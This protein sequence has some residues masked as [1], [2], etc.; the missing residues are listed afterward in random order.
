MRGAV[1]T[2]SGPVSALPGAP[3]AVVAVIM[4][5]LVLIPLPRSGAAGA[6]VPSP[7]NY[8][9]SVGDSYASGYQPVASATAH[10]DT[11]G[12]AYQVVGL[13]RAKGYRFVLRNFGCGGATTTTIL[14]QRG[15]SVPASGP[16]TVSYPSQTQ[17]AA[18]D[19]FL[20][21]HRGHIGLVTV[22]IGGNDLL[23]C[24]NAAIVLSCASQA[25][26]AMTGEVAE[27]LSGLRHAAGPRVPIVGIT[28]PD[29]FLGLDASPHTGQQNLATLSVTEFRSI[30]NPALR[31]LYAS[32]GATFVDVTRATGAY[33]PLT[34]TTDDG[35]YGTIP[36][37][38]A[39]VCSLTYYCGRQD[40]HPTT[41]GYRVIARLIVKTLPRTQ[42]PVPATTMDDGSLVPSLFRATN[43]PGTQR[44]A[45]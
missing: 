5:A 39:Y 30:F 33:T 42:P 20:S 3:V 29:V 24:S 17:A 38:A 1:H 45:S 31:A 19:R 37:A 40:V 35:H 8:D 14:R 13:A 2:R 22:S 6:S 32:A 26:T 21:R 7:V 15:C 41:E 44:G 10:R 23:G 25:V 36:A 27:L 43:G 18:V 9:V 28:Y 34:T 16:D 4:T 12:F 11:H